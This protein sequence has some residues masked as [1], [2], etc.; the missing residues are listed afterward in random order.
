MV[1]L[2]FQKRTVR[3]YVNARLTHKYD[4]HGDWNADAA[5][6]IDLMRVSPDVVDAAVPEPEIAA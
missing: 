5:G 1:A 4:M 2:D 6:L 3:R